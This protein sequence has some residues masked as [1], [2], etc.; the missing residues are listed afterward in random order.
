MQ[1]RNRKDPFGGWASLNEQSASQLTI[2]QCASHAWLYKEQS[3]NYLQ[4]IQINLCFRGVWKRCY[5]RWPPPMIIRPSSSRSHSQ[6]GCQYLPS[7]LPIDCINTVQ[8]PWGSV[9]LSHSKDV[10]S[11]IIHYQLEIEHHWRDKDNNDFPSNDKLLAAA[12]FSLTYIWL[13]LLNLAWDK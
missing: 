5:S 8:Y 10:A 7:K 3:E 4:S 9:D 11:P 1:Q 6:N 13:S 12:L 2:Q